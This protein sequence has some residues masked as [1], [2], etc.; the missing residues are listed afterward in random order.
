MNPVETAVD[1]GSVCRPANR[2]RRRDFRECFEGGG[3]C[4]YQPRKDEPVHCVDSGDA[5]PGC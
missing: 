5:P 1:C 3:F 2:S 4:V